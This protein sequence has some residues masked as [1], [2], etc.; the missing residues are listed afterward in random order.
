[1]DIH[2]L[3]DNNEVVSLPKKI[4][5]EVSKFEKHPHIHPYLL[6]YIHT[7]IHTL[8]TWLTLS[9]KASLQVSHKTKNKPGNY[10]KVLFKTFA[11]QSQTL[12]HYPPPPHPPEASSSGLVWSASSLDRTFPKKNWLRIAIFP[13]VDSAIQLLNNQG[14]KV[15]KSKDRLVD[16]P[17]S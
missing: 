7:H 16:K 3:T 10:I 13:A 9:Y 2:R 12:I 4:N 17:R 5:F 15:S 6:T 8:L 14:L 1:M 11:I